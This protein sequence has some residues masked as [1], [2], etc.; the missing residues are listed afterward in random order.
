[1]EGDKQNSRGVRAGR[2]RLSVIGVGDP[3]FQFPLA[4]LNLKLE[5]PALEIRDWKAPEELVSMGLHRH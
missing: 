5:S 4:L 3:A 1:M 2:D